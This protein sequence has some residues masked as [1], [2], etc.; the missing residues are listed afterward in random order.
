MFLV[1]TFNNNGSPTTELLLH[2][3]GR[4]LAEAPLQH[5]AGQRHQVAAAWRSRAGA[6]PALAGRASGRY[7]KH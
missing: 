2:R 5:A 1:S 6:P 3:G 4:R 7:D